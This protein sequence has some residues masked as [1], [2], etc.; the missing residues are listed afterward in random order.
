MNKVEVFLRKHSST[1][2]TVMGATGVVTTTVLAVKAT[3][4]ALTLLEEAK[5]EKGEEL[6]VAETVKTAWK[7]Y[8]PATITGIS[9]IA[10]I[11][12]IN[13]LSARNQATLMSAYAVLDRSYKEYREKTMELFGEDADINV[14]QEI[15]K[16]KYHNE[17]K[18]FFV[19]EDG[20]ELFFDYEGV[21]WF[22]STVEEV[23]EAA[24]RFNQN[25]TMSGFG[26]VNEFYDILGLERTDTGYQLGWSTVTNDTIYGHDGFKVEL[27]KTE[28]EGGMEC[29]IMTYP[30]PPTTDFVY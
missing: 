19:E 30:C 26:C 7:P 11:F 5:E 22:W 10:C 21:R 18:D 4:K 13:Y 24:Y 15:V 9:T 12:G 28:M 23:K 3:P 25:L 8:I 6:T 17:D 27:E 14:R 1:I 29:W 2:L 20:K 16:T